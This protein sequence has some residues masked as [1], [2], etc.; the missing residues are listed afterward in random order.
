ME[1]G[2]N[3]VFYCRLGFPDDAYALLK[4]RYARR[5]QL[6]LELQLVFDV[7]MLQV[8]SCEASVWTMNDALSSGYVKI[9]GDVTHSFNLFNA[10]P[11]SIVHFIRCFDKSWPLVGADLNFWYFPSTYLYMR[12]FNPRKNY[13]ET[14]HTPRYPTRRRRNATSHLSD[15]TFTPWPCN[16]G[17]TC[18]TCPKL[19]L[20][21]FWNKHNDTI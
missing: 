10:I 14:I 11:C 9:D 12:F 6:Q 16:R 13:L 20:K 18:W 1:L 4:S 19:S 7:E 17:S 21:C 2:C 8:Q 5:M 15:F 3:W